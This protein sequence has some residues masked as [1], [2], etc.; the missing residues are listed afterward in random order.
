MAAV[1]YAG[2]GA[3]LS[4]ATAAW[5]VGLADSRPYMIDVSTPRRINS[6]PGV[7]VHGRREIE[8]A[9]HNGLPVTPFVQTLRDYSST[10][11][12][13]K[14]RRALALAD[15]ES[16][17][18]AEAIEAQLPRSTPTRLRVGLKRHRPGR[19]RTKSGLEALFHDLCEENDLPPPET[20][21]RVA[22][23]EVDALWRKER[24]VVEI[25]GP[26]NH[27]TPAQIRRDHRKDLELRAAGIRV[28]RYSDEQVEDHFRAVADEIQRYLARG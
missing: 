7:R 16:P 6:T 9:W 8:R 5:W 27:R 18:D 12:L 2:P 25:D 28:L 13:T 24:L 19:A 1:L 21:A 4:H 17:L 23:W 10:A 11:S 20:N 15:F 3:M 22:G 14:V 26:A